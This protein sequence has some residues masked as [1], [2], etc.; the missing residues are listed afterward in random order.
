MKVDPNPTRKVTEQVSY[1]ETG[2]ELGT[3]MVVELAASE[4][5]RGFDSQL[6]VELPKWRT[7]S[8]FISHSKKTYI[9]VIQKVLHPV[10]LLILRE[11]LTDG[12]LWQGRK[13]CERLSPG[14]LGQQTR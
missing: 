13:S 3:A 12:R 1:Q 9:F 2:P 7:W 6:F 4:R 14:E 5:S 11:S 10:G 8:A